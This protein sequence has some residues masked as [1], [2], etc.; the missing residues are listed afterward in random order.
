PITLE[1]LAEI[2]LSGKLCIVVQK[3]KDMQRGEG[4]LALIQSWISVS[5]DNPKNQDYQPRGNADMA[6][7]FWDEAV[8]S[9]SGVVESFLLDE[10]FQV[11]SFCKKMTAV[12]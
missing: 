9:M 1:G 2:S 11:A 8:S 12:N 5:R 6:I 4:E 10:S 3:A 7:T